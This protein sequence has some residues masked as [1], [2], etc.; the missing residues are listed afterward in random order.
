MKGVRV[1]ITE[2]L[3]RDALAFGDDVHIYSIEKSG[4]EEFTLVVTG[5]RFEEVA[6]GS[7]PPLA[8]PTIKADLD[9]RPVDTWLEIEWNL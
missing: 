9:K 5:E 8:S 1:K 6:E 2:Q 4:Y 3:I 7:E